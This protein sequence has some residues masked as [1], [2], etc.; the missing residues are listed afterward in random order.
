MEDCR[1]DGRDEW[2][3]G[4]IKSGYSSVPKVLPVYVAQLMG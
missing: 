3:T 4:G 2:R 1:Y